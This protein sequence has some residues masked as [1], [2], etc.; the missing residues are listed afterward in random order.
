MTARERLESYLDA[1]RRRLLAH[2]YVRAA[3]VAA[4]A[5]LLI[6]CATVWWLQ[7]EEFAP[8]ITI[9]GRGA[10]LVMLLAVGALLWCAVA[11]PRARVGVRKPSS[12]TCRM[13]TVASRPTST[14]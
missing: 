1:L 4:V 10:L 9:A 13:S 12:V 5:T 14:T 7:R 8:S 2:I 3:A 11:A 6:T